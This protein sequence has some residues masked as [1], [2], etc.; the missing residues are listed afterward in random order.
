M[1]EA[2]LNDDGMLASHASRTLT[3][4]EISEEKPELW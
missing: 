4:A 3:V 1:V 2:P